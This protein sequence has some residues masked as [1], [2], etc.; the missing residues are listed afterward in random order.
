MER[1]TPLYELHESLGGKIVPFA[2]YLLA[3]QYPNGVIREHMAVRE[4]CGIF[5]VSHMGEVLFEGPD[6]LKALN[7]LMANDL[8]GMVDGQVRYSPMLNEEGGIV[9]DLVVC[10]F[11]DVRYMAVVNAANRAKDVD[12]MRAHLEG[13]VLMTDV[14]DDWAQIALQG[15]LSRDILLT[16]SDEAQIPK[17]YYS[18]TPEAV[19]AGIP[20]MLSR[21]GYT[22]ELGYEL[23][24]K[25]RDAEKMFR[26][27]LE[28]GAE[29]CGLGARDT[30]RLE[31]S[32][33]LYGHEMT[34][35]ISPIEAG[36]SW[37]VKPEHEFIGRD[38]ML[39]RG[40]PRARVGL[41]ITGKGIAR[42]GQDV[43]LADEKIGVTTS[44]T[45]LPH[46]GGAYAMAL[47]RSEHAQIGTVLDVDVRGRRVSAE[48]APLPFYKRQ[49]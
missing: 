49:K 39:R 15:P 33:P 44:G 47:I 14:S 23:Y 16:L 12:W 6:A 24:T 43:Y 17:K 19:V 46:L 31:A 22:G 29:P 21:T 2:G 3:V 20:C 11:S 32:M 42:E 38:A 7:R 9:D 36:L 13:N 26:A 28:A 30:L 4:R 45:H 25:P 41:K 34:D 18:F 5:D 40:K 8:S 35:D 27:L 10:R 1:K 37:A 48:I